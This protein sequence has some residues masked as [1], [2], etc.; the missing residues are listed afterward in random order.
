MTNDMSMPICP[1]RWPTLAFTECGLRRLEEVR[2]YLDELDARKHP[3]AAA[4]R[5]EFLRR[6]DYLAS[7]GGEVGDGDRRRRFRVRL[8]RDWAP[9]SFG[10]LWEALEPTSGLYRYAFEGGLIFHGGGDPL[11]VSL[12]PQFYGI[13]S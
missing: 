4:I 9:G 8:S 10:L 5:D 1:S 12:T 3:N 6:M 13:H 2:E 7:Y 11:C